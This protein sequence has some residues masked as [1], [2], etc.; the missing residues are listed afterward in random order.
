MGYFHLVLFL[1]NHDS[2]RFHQCVLAICDKVTTYIAIV[3]RVIIAQ[4]QL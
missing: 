2:K 1:P 4:A 3:F